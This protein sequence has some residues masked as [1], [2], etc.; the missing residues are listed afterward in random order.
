M[1]D[2]Y[3]H[4][5]IFLHPIPLEKFLTSLVNIKFPSELSV[6]YS[7]LSLKDSDC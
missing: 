7:R 3:G 1:E 5:S 6:S 4:G 2:F